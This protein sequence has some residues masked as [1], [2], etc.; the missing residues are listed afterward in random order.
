MK[1]IATGLLTMML[2]SSI[3]ISAQTDLTAELD[4]TQK[5][6]NTY[7]APANNVKKLTIEDAK[8]LAV[9]NSNLL[10]SAEIKIE[11]DEINAREALATKERTP[12][13]S[14]PPGYGGI[15]RVET[16]L[17]RRG[18]YS[19]LAEMA[20]ILSK[21]SKER[22]I[23]AIEFSAVS[24]YYSLANSQESLKTK[25][26]SLEIAVE[27]LR[28]VNLMYELGTV[29]RL[30]VQSAEFAVRQTELELDSIKR[31]VEFAKISFNNVL[32]LDENAEVILTDSLEVKE[33]QEID[34][35]ESVSSAL[36]NRFEVIAA[37]LQ[38]AAAEKEA[39]AY[40][41]FYTRQTYFYKLKEFNVE[42]NK[43]ILENTKNSIELSIK[44]AYYDYLD[45]YNSVLL[46]DIAVQSAELMHGLAKSK[47]ET[48]A[49]TNLEVIEAQNNL[50]SAK[51]RKV[52]AQTGFYLT[53]L[54]FDIQLEVGIDR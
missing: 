4:N 1:K 27:N 13:N 33:I 40:G 35:E 48:G 3:H 20:F 47:F 26:E 34:V 54:A 16:T 39:E 32:G 15:S 28:A 7:D 14:L 17:T 37:E 30:E 21:L 25:K 38:L 8:R 9:E 43:T 6:E 53:K 24:E 11:S 45:S 49:G 46:S 22:I 52:Q 31:G 29:S 5:I 2:I 44:K 19:D 50:D 36:E 18:Y 41:A 23:N 51:L 12:N 10:K 42:S